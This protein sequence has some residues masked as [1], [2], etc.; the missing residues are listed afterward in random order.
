[1][2]EKCKGLGAELKVDTDR[3]SPYRAYT[4]EKQ[5]FTTTSDTIRQEIE[6]FMI[7]HGYESVEDMKGIT[8]KHMK[9]EVLRTKAVPPG[10]DETKCTGC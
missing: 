4:L 7:E 3:V 2:C 6:K 1:M 5:Y 9:D 10:V 8:L